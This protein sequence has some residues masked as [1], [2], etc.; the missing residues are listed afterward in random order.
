[1][2]DREYI[3]TNVIPVLHQILQWDGNAENAVEFADKMYL[4][5]ENMYYKLIEHLGKQN[6]HD[7]DDKIM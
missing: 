1:M 4:N 7:M 6:Q 5:I 3:E 2:N